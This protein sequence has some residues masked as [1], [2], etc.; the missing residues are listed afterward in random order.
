MPLLKMGILSKEG[1]FSK[2]S[3]L[4]PFRVDPFPG[5]F[6]FYLEYTSFRDQILS[7]LE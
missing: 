3:K 7:F 5:E 4:C 2:G 1:I 6:F